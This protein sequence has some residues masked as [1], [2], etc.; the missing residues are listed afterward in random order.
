MARKTKV[1]EVN[2]SELKSYINGAIEFNDKN[3]IPN[4]EQWA[5]I[6]EMI[7]NVK[8][9]EVFAHNTRANN[10]VTAPQSRLLAGQQ[11]TVDDDR[12]AATPP[13]INMMKVP[14]PIKQAEPMRDEDGV[15]Q[16]GILR[17][18]PVIHNKDGEYKSPYD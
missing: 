17:K 5:K 2:I 13:K 6:V 1:R 3:W 16:S 7:R 9:S 15:I 18:T 11:I 8:E 4:A 14:A 12:T 10:A